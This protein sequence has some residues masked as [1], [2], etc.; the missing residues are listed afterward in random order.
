MSRIQLRNQGKD[1][2]ALRDFASRFC[3]RHQLPV[4]E[5]AR[6]LVILD[7][8]FTNVVSYGYIDAAQGHIE[9]RLSVDGDK[10]VIEFVDDGIR[11]D[12]LTRP[13]AD[14]SLPLEDRPIG[15]IGIAIV[16]ALVDQI[17]YS[18]QRNRNCLM[19]TR[20]FA[21]AVDATIKAPTG[22]QD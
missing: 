17:D 21:A 4:D 13:P 9:V 1:G 10:L 8:L 7:E 2:I 22:A 20:R 15:G 16:L 18:R 19:L 14:L 6:L 3:R 11:F 12:P 5:R